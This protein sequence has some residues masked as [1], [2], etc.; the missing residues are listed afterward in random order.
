LET[1]ST[2]KRWTRA[3][4]EELFF[5]DSGTTGKERKI[6]KKQLRRVIGKRLMNVF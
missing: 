4:G 1:N 6:R 5:W 3:T 2:G